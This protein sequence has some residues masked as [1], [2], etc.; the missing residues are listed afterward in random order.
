MHKR[1]P[2]NACPASPPRSIW[3]GGNNPWPIADDAR[4][5]ILDRCGRPTECSP[6]RCVKAG[7]RVEADI[8]GNTIR[9]VLL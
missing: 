1:A 7:E 9:G 3:D 4:V 2:L 6:V 5:L 8:A